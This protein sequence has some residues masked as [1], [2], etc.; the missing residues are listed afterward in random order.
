MNVLD[1]EAVSEA[2]SA[3]NANADAEAPPADSLEHSLEVLSALAEGIDPISGDRLP[4][5]C[6]EPAIADALQVAVAALRARV[7][8]RARRARLPAN[9]GKPWRPEDDAALL[10][11][12]AAGEALEALAQR[13]GRTRVGIRSRLE[14]HG[15]LASPPRP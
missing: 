14:R 7:Q 5:I 1:R 8:Q 6:L 10:A 11:A 2:D 13:F 3:A 12:W 15:R 4:A 9:V